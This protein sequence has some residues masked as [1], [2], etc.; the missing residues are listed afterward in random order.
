MTKPAI[1]KRTTKGSLLTYE[2]LD[3]NFQN[4]AD[5]TITVTGD[6]G[7][8]TN[9]LNDSMKVSGGTGLTSVASGTQL[10]L[11]LD[12]TAVTPGTYTNANITVD[13]QG[14][15]TLASNGSAGGTINSG[16]ATKLAFYPSAGTTIDDTGISYSYSAPGAYQQLDVGSDVLLLKTVGLHVYRTSPSVGTTITEELVGANRLVVSTATSGKPH[17]SASNQKTYA[18]NEA[19]VF[20]DFAGIIVVYDAASSANQKMTMWLCGGQSATAI[21]STGTTNNGIV[22]YYPASPFGYQWRNNSGGVKTVNIMAFQISAL[23]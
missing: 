12:D 5:A 18:I 21:G 8:I 7:S 14:R 13:A 4:L 23:A 17:I 19:E 10:T 16:A 11:N 1:T 20:L 9:N 15:I 22:E 2:E 3:Q 6:S